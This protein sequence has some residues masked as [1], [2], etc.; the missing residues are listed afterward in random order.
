M[1]LDAEVSDGDLGFGGRLGTNYLLSE[2]T[3]MYL[4]YSLENERTDNG[5]YSRRGDLVSGVKR[6]LSDATSVYVEER[7][8]DTEVLEA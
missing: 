2:R 1:R 3:N 7:Y 5:L 4:N 8:Q 6:R